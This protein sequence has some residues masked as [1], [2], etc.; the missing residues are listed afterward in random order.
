MMPAQENILEWSRTQETI[1]TQEGS[2]HPNVS[3]TPYDIQ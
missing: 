1:P 3:E 2:T